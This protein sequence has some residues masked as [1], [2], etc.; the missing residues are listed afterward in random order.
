MKKPTKKFNPFSLITQE[1]VKK[2]SGKT[3]S[4]NLNNGAILKSADSYKELMIEMEEFLN[5][6]VIYGVLTL[7]K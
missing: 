7:P 1:D 2:Y 5:T 4:V 3:I 6:D